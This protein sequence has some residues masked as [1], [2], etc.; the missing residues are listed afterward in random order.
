MAN[1]ELSCDATMQ[2]N[3]DAWFEEIQGFGGSNPLRNFEPNAFG[4]IDLERS[5]PG[6]Y[7]QLITGRPTLLSNLV[8]DPLAYSRALSASRRIKQKAQRL[9]AN[10]GLN[11]IHLAGGLADFTADG[12]DLSVPILLWPIQ[13]L[14]R[15]DDYE[16]EI[17][18]APFVN[19]ELLAALKH[20]FD[21]TINSDELLARQLEASD[22]VPITLL[23]Y[24]A[25]ATNARANIG[26]SRVLV[27]SNFVTELADLVADFDR[28]ERGLLSALAGSPSEGLA[29]IDIPELNLVSDADSTQM[30]I[31]ARAMAGQSFAVETLPGCGYTQTVV[32]VLAA[33]ADQGKRALVVAPRVETIEN[34]VDRFSEVGL[35]AL[36]IRG[37][38]A[39]VDIIGAI[40]RN[41]KAQPV[42]LEGSRAARIA[43]ESTIDSY[44]EVLNTPDIKL[45]V[46]IAEALKQLSALTGMARAP[47]TSARIER[48]ALEAGLDKTSALELLHEA[49]DLGEYQYGPQDTAWFQAQ[50]DSPDEVHQALKVAVRLRD[51]S[52]PRLSN[53]LTEFIQNVKFKPAA[54]VEDWGQYLRLFMGIRET[55]DR[56]VGDVFDR[57]LT[58]LIAATSARQGLTR[59]REMSGSNRRRLKKLAKEYLRAGVHVADINSSLRAVDEQRELWNRYSLS[60]VPPQVPAG[61]NDAQVAY[62]SFVA[63]L[64]IIQRHLDPMSTEPPLIRLPLRDLQTKLASLAEDTDSLANLGERVLVLKKI[65]QAGLGA[66]SR[67]LAKLH[68]PI[69]RIASELDLAWWQ[70][71]LEIIV[72]RDSRILSFVPSV[73]EAN[74][75]QFRAAYE[76]QI[77]LGSAS[78]AARLADKWHRVIADFAN[79]AAALKQELRSGTTTLRRVAELAPNIFLALTPVIVVSPFQVARQLNPSEVFD[80]II[81]LDA[82]GSTVAENLPA[83]RRGGQLIA[84]GDDAI[85]EPTGFEIEVHPAR[86]GDVGAQSSAPALSVY[87]L[88]RR[89]FG[90]EVLRR[91]YRTTGQALSTLINTEFYQNRIEFTPSVDEYFGNR[92][93]NLE[94]ITAD[95]RAK[96]TIEG[97]TESLDAEVAHVV[98][99]VLN[100]A[101]WRPERSLLVAT[102]SAVHAERISTSI[103][104]ELQK[105]PDLVEFFNSHGREQF[106][107][108]ALSDLTHR[109]A[110]RVIFSIGFGRTQ[111]G[112][113]LS[114]FGELS[115]ANGRRYLANLLVS[116]RNEIT[117]VSCFAAEDVPSDRLS[118]GALLLRELLEAGTRPTQELDL[119][120]DPMLQDLNLRL[121]K[122]GVRVDVSFSASTPMVASYGKNAA[123]IEPDWSI[124]GATR[125]ER[126]RL[127]PRLLESLGWQYIRVYSFELFS[128][129]QALAQRIAVKLGVQVGRQPQSLFDEKAFED[130]DAAW[131][132]TGKSNDQQLKADKPPHWG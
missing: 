110:D 11:S 82:A 86:S 53:Q 84:F 75:S 89:V 122:L 21:L 92:N 108:V 56:F 109:V 36:A 104:Q 39:W 88:A 5:H 118:N 51:E 102:A 8:R 130:T 121:K 55:L 4:Q 48:S 16:F 7:S 63:D 1:S 111:H 131:G 23:N 18:G 60:P 46:S 107:V 91:S 85:S 72:A 90:A 57:P 59:D 30:R 68:T 114:N 117:V 69:E 112:A 81:V 101:L 37:G 31:V 61:I 98:E 17:S 76:A 77:A 79:E 83:L 78:V 33:L 105:K 96:T 45:G 13:L 62:Q 42:D 95:N 29:P 64:D 12:I 3:W 100:H 80:V 49:S 40:S 67:D 74:E 32:N 94:V 103:R 54:T 120:H 129:P 22:L 35:P 47:E 20:N 70:S 38:S 127:R 15:G 19:P 132:D 128:D 73:I 113:V 26:L 126:F 6:G 124:P 116:A 9:S 71:A 93:F 119:E 24:L 99:A 52:Y 97:A 58:E 123:V 106:E 125:T 25:F 27:I 2:A 87:Q 41:E 43:A 34:L 50:F 44:F 66:L 115:Q 65:R 10:F 28:S 14:Q